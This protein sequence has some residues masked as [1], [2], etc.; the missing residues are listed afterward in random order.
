MR[1]GIILGVKASS[2]QLL[3]SE[4]EEWRACVAR[5][6]VSPKILTR[7]WVLPGGQVALF[8]GSGGES[9]GVPRGLVPTGPRLDDMDVGSRCQYITGA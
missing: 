3:R 2:D 8:D 6:H 4:G 1:S 7:G 9:D 5:S